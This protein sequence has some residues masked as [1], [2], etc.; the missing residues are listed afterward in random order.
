MLSQD[1]RVR[2]YDWFADEGIKRPFAKYDSLYEL[3]L[4]RKFGNITIYTQLAKVLQLPRRNALITPA[5]EIGQG[6]IVRKVVC[7]RSRSDN[8]T[9]EPT[10]IRLGQFGSDAQPARKQYF[11]HWPQKQ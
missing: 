2:P 11:V 5:D 9:P 4:V 1:C 7:L 8:G 6:Q 3:K 10:P